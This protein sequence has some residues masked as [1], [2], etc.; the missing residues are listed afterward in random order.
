MKALKA[1]RGMHDIQPNDTELWRFVEREI[2][3]VLQQYGYQEMRL[4]LLEMTALFQRGVGENTDIVEKEMYSFLDRNGESLTL[5]PELTASIVRAGIEHGLFYNQIQKIWSMGALFRYERPQK[6]RSRQFHQCSVEC[7][8]VQSPASDA[9]L[10]M[11]CARIWSRLHVSEYLK[12]E[13]NTLG[14]QIERQAYRMSLVDYLTPYTNDLD[15]DSQRR[16]ISNPLR[17][18]DSKIPLTQ[19]ILSQAPTMQDYLGSESTAFFEQICI[20]LDQ[21]QIKYHINP[22][23]VRGLDYYSHTV[24]EWKTEQLGSQGTVCGGGRYDGLVEQLGGKATSATG[25]AIGFERLLLLLEATLVKDRLLKKE[26]ISVTLVISSPE[27]IP[28]SMDLL[29]SIRNHFP[30]I[31][32]LS[33]WSGSLKS[34]IKRAYAMGSQLALMIGD[35]E[36]SGKTITI[37]FLKEDNKTETITKQALFELLQNQTVNHNNIESLS[38]D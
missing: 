5:R 23:L 27:S 3:A 17:I 13:I 16:L 8:G 35:Q 22:Q 18:L 25:F 4:P 14:S 21:R 33:A 38:A 26:E 7:F 37:R 9:E 2:K 28:Y 1:V 20:L 15:E 24:F 31:E 29:E 12:L 30:K 34:Q 11:I 10:M 32:V 6:G 36:V 19:D